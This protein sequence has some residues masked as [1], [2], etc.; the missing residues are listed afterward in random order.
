MHYKNMDA[1][2]VA[3]NTYSNTYKYQDHT[4][5]VVHIDDSMTGATEDFKYDR[6]GNLTY[7]TNSNDIDRSLYWDESNRLRV[8]NDHEGMQHYIYDAS[9]ERI[10][11]AN[12]NIEAVYGNGSLLEIGRAHV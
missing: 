2:P 4:H 9:G 6:N 10:L 1:T 3:A 8:V 11:K 12:S 7:K 5:K